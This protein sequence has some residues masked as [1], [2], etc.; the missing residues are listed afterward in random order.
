MAYQYVH[1]ALFC[2]ETKGAADVGCHSSVHMLL[3][4][5]STA[6]ALTAPHNFFLLK[7]TLKRT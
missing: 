6:S 2:R 1:L 5:E 4:D 7:Q 3:D